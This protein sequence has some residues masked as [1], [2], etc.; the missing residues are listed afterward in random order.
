MTIKYKPIRAN[1]MANAFS[2]KVE[3]VNA[4]QLEGE[5]QASQLHFNFLFRITDRL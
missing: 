1:V 2:R 5:D 3:L 4:M